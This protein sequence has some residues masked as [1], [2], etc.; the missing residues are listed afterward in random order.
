VLSN[1]CLLVGTRVIVD[2]ERKVDK[3][4]DRKMAENGRDTK[5][6]SF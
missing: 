5:V 1:A 6:V 3:K 4:V 2:V